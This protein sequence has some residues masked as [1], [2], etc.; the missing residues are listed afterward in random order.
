[1]KDEGRNDWAGKSP[2]EADFVIKQKSQERF[3]MDV[4]SYFNNALSLTAEYPAAIGKS[5]QWYQAG[6]N[7]NNMMILDVFAD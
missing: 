3:K 2:T 5:L 1:M 7:V 4:C 6:V